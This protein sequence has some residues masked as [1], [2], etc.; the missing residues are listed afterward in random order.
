MIPYG[1]ISWSLVS[2]LMFAIAR[3]LR[4]RRQGWLSE[5]AAALLAGLMAGVAA[6]V[7]NFGGWQILEPAAIAF[8]ALC[9]AGAIAMLRLLRS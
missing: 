2:L 1:L 3:P 5:L 8:A 7:M 9:A 4:R 6:T